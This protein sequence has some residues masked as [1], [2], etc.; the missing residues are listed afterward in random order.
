MQLIYHYNLQ[1]VY[2]EYNQ[3]FY[4]IYSNQV[5]IFFFSKL[6]SLANFSANLSAPFAPPETINLIESI[7]YNFKIFVFNKS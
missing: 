1:F 3:L 2:Y 6:N 4:H 7:G 5:R